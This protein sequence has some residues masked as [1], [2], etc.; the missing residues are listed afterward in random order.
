M[1]LPGDL[2]ALRDSLPS[3]FERG[4]EKFPEPAL[5]VSEPSRPSLQTNG[6]SCW[7][8]KGPALDIFNLLREDI[9]RLLHN[10]KEMFEK[11]EEKSTTVE[12]S[13]FMVGTQPTNASPTI[14]FSSKSARQRKYA[15]AILKASSILDGHAFVK[16]KTLDKM[17]PIPYA[18]SSQSEASSNENGV[19]LLDGT[20]SQCGARIAVGRGRKAIL[21]G[22]LRVGDTYNGITAQHARWE[23]EDHDHQSNHARLP[24][25][26]EDSDDDSEDSIAMTSKGTYMCTMTYRS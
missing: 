15:K 9:V 23:T 4:K 6:V 3:V 11:G 20:D 22:V 16:I 26:D 12:F 10:H 18:E 1:H 17:P 2:R 21:G 25:F 5:S 13:M 8:I 24:C 19:F 14:V 7:E